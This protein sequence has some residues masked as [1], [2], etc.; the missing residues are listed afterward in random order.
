MAVLESLAAGTPVIASDAD[1]LPELWADV[2]VIL[3]RPI[4]YSE[5]S[6]HI[7]RFLESPKLWAETSKRGQLFA[8]SYDWSVVARKYLVASM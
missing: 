5:W 8:R 7:D 3:P 2:S 4:D 6:E 1:A